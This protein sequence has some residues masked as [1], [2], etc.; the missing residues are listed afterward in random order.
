[1]A[2]VTTCSDFGAPK[3]KSVTVSIVSPSICHEVMGL[4][5]MILVLWMLNF[6]PDFSFSL[7]SRGS[8][9]LLCFLPYG[10]CHLNIWGYW[11]FSWQSWFQ[12][13]L[14]SAPVCMWPSSEGG[15]HFLHYL[16]HS[17]VSGQTTG[18]E[19]STIQQ[20]KIELKIYWAWPCPS[21]QDPV[22][23]SVSLSHQEAFIAL[24]FLSI[25]GQTEWKPQLQN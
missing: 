4:D 8:L 22:S 13:L 2:A 20:Q 7:S 24:L 11:Y 12:L 23:P 17:L 15:L 6:K 19:H 5:A 9:V 25:R 10:W 1:M 16:H 21:K 18:R 14:H 3:I